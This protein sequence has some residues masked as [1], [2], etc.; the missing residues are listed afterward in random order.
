M[1][2]YSKIIT[3]QQCLF[4]IRRPYESTI[5]TF[6]ANFIKILNERLIVSLYKDECSFDKTGQPSIPLSWIIKIESLNDTII[7]SDTIFPNEI[8][9]EIDYYV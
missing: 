4:Y 6:Q 5:K 2:D 8:L 1:T 7:E 3:N 9:L